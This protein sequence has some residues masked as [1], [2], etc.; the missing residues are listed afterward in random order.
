ML[1]V[2]PCSIQ[3]CDKCDCVGSVATRV[4]ASMWPQPT[5][6]RQGIAASR[7]SQ[8]GV[9]SPPA[10]GCMHSMACCAVLNPRHICRA[11]ERSGDAGRVAQGSCNLGARAC[12]WE[13]V[14][15]CVCG[16]TATTGAAGAQHGA[17]VEHTM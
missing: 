2:N 9:P 6:S 12:Q 7:V 4:P 1:V 8:M 10:A 17:R 3:H 5:V 16:T 14:R 11:M 13:A 15:M